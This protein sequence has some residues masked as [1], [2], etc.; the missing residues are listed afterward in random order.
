MG[1]GG[2]GGGG[3]PLP[4]SA[5]VLP[6]WPLSGLCYKLKLKMF[7]TSDYIMLV[8]FYYRLR[9]VCCISKTSFLDSEGSLYVSGKNFRPN[10][11][12]H[13]KKKKKK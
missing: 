13:S 2:G 7:V 3:C 4:G 8:G 6:R 11:T 10:N 9:G 12:V 5:P 1:G